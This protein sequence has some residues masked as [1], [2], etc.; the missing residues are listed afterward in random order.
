MRCAMPTS[1]S[2]KMLR[3]LSQSSIN[4]E[5]SPSRFSTSK[6]IW[7]RSST[8]RMSIEPYPPRLLSPLPT[9]HGAIPIIFPA[10]NPPAVRNAR[11]GYVDS[12][13]LRSEFPTY[14]PPLRRRGDISTLANRGHLYFGLTV[15]QMLT[16]Y[17]RNKRCPYLVD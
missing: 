7:P 14:P 5:N 12:S 16:G 15:T 1:P 4:P 2:A 13:P 17:S 10:P 11:G 9:I 8:Q 6:N 3:L